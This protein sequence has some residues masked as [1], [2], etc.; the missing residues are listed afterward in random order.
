MT[1][2]WLTS[3]EIAALVNPDL[4]RKNWAAL[5]VN[6]ERPTCRV[7]GAFLEDGTLVE[8]FTM[9]LVP[10]LGPM[11]RHDNTI[12]D[13]GETSRRLAAVMED[14]LRNEVQARDFMAIADSPLTKRLC[15]RFGMK[16]VR[17]PVFMNFPGEN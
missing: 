13:S 3:D 1:Y 12:R 8:S 5:N 10:M 14:F 17:V 7:L 11:L 4:E 9:Q 15:E 2:R 6:D 16:L